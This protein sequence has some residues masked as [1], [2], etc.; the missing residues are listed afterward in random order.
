[1]SSYATLASPT[2]TGD[3]KA[4]TPSAGDNDTSIATTAFVTT[5]NPDATT[6]VKGHVQ[7]ATQAE[8]DAGT[9]STKAITPSTLLLN[10]VTPYLNQRFS[11]SFA[12]ATSGA[13]AGAA[14][15]DWG[16]RVFTGT[17]SGATALTRSG[18]NATYPISRGKA[19]GIVNYSKVFIISGTMDASQYVAN[20][21]IRFTFGKNGTD[22]TGDLTRKGIG[23]RIVG[24]GAVELIVHNGTSQS[25]VTSSFTP[26]ANTAFDFIIYADGAGNVTLYIND[27]SVATSANGPT[28]D[29]TNTADYIQIEAVTS[30]VLS[31]Q[32]ISQVGNV[33]T[34]FGR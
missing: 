25:N 16:Q 2:F 34:Y 20:S 8:T 10:Q 12:S 6:S 15:A 28:G 18:S 27:S 1:M 31:A 32:T 23:L 24:T 29:S 22:G 7:L 26:T 17:S 4:P 3:P 21:T 14:S 11:S 33:K 30:A 13:G 19:Q 9:N 5:A